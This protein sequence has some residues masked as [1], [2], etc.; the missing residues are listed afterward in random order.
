M[1]VWAM[2]A[3]PGFSAAGVVAECVCGRDLGDRLGADGAGGNRAEQ[4]GLVDL[5]GAGGEGEDGQK[6]ASS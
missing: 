1:S 5:G 2:E 3:W 6:E 4:S